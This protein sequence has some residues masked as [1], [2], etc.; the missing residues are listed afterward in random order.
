MKRRLILLFVAAVIVAGGAIYRF[1]IRAPQPMILTGVVTTDDVRVG[2]MIQGR[3]E[4]LDVKPGDVV[5]EGQLLARIQPQEAKADVEF[6]RSSQE[7]SASAVDEAEAHI[8]FLEMQTQE[9][10]R[11][12]EAN[13][14]VSRAQ[15]QQAHADLEN[16]ELQFT[17][18]RDLRERGLNSPQALDLARTNYDSAKAHAEALEKQ[19][20]AADAALSLAKANLE[21]IGVG[22]AALSSANR[23]LAAAGAQTEKAKVR[24]AY[25]E[26]RAPRSGIVD[27]RA[28]LQGEI[29]NPGDTIV[30]LVDPDD[31]WIRAD[32]EESYIDRVRLG[33][34]L[35]VRLPSKSMAS[36]SASAIS[37]PST[38]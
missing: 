36:R 1:A 21:Q 13:V 37:A 16:A 11:Q 6:Y 8:R 28:A 32:V 18:E 2:A 7:A 9:Q 12:A 14:A 15:A 17:R 27:V 3:L 35:G 34:T 33:D 4:E 10:I 19:V 25:T 29:V 38:A 26:V 24:L 31:L 20:Q 30:T 5:E 23:Q 22:K